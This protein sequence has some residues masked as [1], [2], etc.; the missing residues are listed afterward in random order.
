LRAARSIRLLENW[1]PI[2]RQVLEDQRGQS[3]P[4]AERKDIRGMLR[5]MRE[6]FERGLYEGEEY[7]YWQEG[8]RFK[9]KIGLAG[10]CS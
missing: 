8:Q 1:E 2:V 3:D 7:Q 9:R 4:E 5:L 6:N 10:A